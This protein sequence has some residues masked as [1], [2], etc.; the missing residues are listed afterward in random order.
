MLAVVAPVRRSVR[1]IERVPALLM[2]ELQNAAL[3]PRRYALEREAVRDATLAEQAALTWLVE[4]DLRTDLRSN[5]FFLHPVLGYAAYRDVYDCHRGEDMREV[6]HIA[7]S[8]RSVV[9]LLRAILASAHE[10]ARRV[11]GALDLE[12]DAMREVAMACG[13]LPQRTIFEEAQ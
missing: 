7:G 8:R 12:N 11:F 2:G 9:Q 3:L 6:V 5:G 4:W 10:Q 1:A 13:F